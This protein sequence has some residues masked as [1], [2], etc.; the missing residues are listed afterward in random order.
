MAHNFTIT[1][2][3]MF[4]F[5]NH[6]VIC[7]SQFTMR[8]LSIYHIL[9]RSCFQDILSFVKSIKFVQNALLILNVKYGCSSVQITVPLRRI[10]SLWNYLLQHSK[11]QTLIS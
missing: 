3:E 4:D 7:S 9:M 10:N 8:R 2:Q 1:V 6:M 11:G 5:Y